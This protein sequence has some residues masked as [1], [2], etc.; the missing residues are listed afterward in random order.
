MY[1]YNIA[2]NIVKKTVSLIGFDYI[3][4]DFTLFDSANERSLLYKNALIESVRLVFQDMYDNNE[5]QEQKVTTLD[6][7]LTDSL[8]LTH[9]SYEVLPIFR[10][11][12][13]YNG[14]ELLTA[15]FDIED[16]L[17]ENTDNNLYLLQPFSVITNVKYPPL[18]MI[19]IPDD[20]YV[21]GNLEQPYLVRHRDLRSDTNVILLEEDLVIYKLCVIMLTLK[22]L[23]TTIFDSL[24]QSKLNYYKSRDAVKSIPN[25]RC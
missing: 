10:I 3:N 1:N 17:K 2:I 4:N 15:T 25:L 18:T 14:R 8:G 5:E 16:L 12:N 6:Y 13:V 22:G 23:N 21:T 11:L 20:V 9:Y 19:Y 24:Y 7:S